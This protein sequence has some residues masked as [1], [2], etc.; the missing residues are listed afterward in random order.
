MQQQSQQ[1]PT[2]EEFRARAFQDPDTGIFIVNGDEPALN[3]ARL[4]EFYDRMIGQKASATEQEGVGQTQQPLT[5][6][7]LPG[8]ANKWSI[9][10]ALNLTY[11]IN[12]ASFGGYYA[13][14]VS[15]MN[16]AAADWKA[17]GASLKF[18]HTSSLDS[19]CNNTTNVVFNVRMVTNMQPTLARAFF[20]G[21]PREAREILIDVSSFGNITPWTLAG[22]LR[23]EL[24]HVLGFRH[25]HVRPEAAA[26]AC[27]ETDSYWRAVTAYDSASVMH[28]PQCNGTNVGDLK[29]TPT[30][31]V[32]VRSHY[33]VA[34]LPEQGLVSGQSISSSDGRFLLY[35]QAD[36]N[37]VHYWNGHGAL[38]STVTGGSQ[39]KSAW[40]QGDGNFVLYTTTTPVVGS[41]LWSS[42]TYGNPGAYLAI[43]NDGNLV[44]YAKDGMTPLW[45][46]NTGGH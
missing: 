7:N 44:V 19:N 45:N 8:W 46:S 18:V 28:Y 38:W 10:A 6:L 43:Q 13:S 20:P 29:L 25:E 34:I 3:E 35:M 1:Q 39:G 2:W 36:G 31:A 4:R 37:L 9:P 41:S 12:S 24:G 21:D 14:V 32:G 23:H 42:I 40:M 33:P 17:T 16:T 27:N 22:I 15:A 30:D 11:C 5:A 26:G